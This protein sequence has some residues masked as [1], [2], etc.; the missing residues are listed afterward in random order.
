MRPT[1]F[2]ITALFLAPLLLVAQ[3]E[4]LIGDTEIEN[5]G[6]GALV[7]RL[8]S[9]ND[10][11]GILVGGRGGWIINHTVSIGF[12]GYGLVN[13]VPSLLPG[14]FG[15]NFVQFGYGG[16]DLEFVINSDRVIHA[17]VHALIGGG[18]AGFR[19]GSFEG[20]MWDNDEFGI[21][22]RT[23]HEQDEFFVVEPGAT[24]DLNVT[25]WFRLSAGASYRYISGMS[26]RATSNTKTG[27]P[28]GLLMFRFGDF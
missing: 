7:I 27:T 18:S 12:G 2:L 28:S 19:Y 9:I 26:T 20:S 4:T 16:L 13:D 21:D 14:P 5:G 25:P 10:E 8:S 6:Y 24:V 22:G 11:A 1:L 23:F 17:S 3:E 15:Q